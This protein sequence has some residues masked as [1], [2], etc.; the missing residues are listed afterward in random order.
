MS[1]QQ[2]EKITKYDYVAEYGNGSLHEQNG[3]PVIVKA[4][5]RKDAD[6][7]FADKLVSGDWDVRRAGDEPRIAAIEA[8]ANAHY[9]I[10]VIDR[11]TAELRE[12]R[13]ELFEKAKHAKIDAYDLPTDDE[14]IP[15]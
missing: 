3:E 11:C 15:W 8:Y 9:E 7:M 5:S 13:A 14:D 6:R 1:K 2:V 12:Q 4:P 10:G